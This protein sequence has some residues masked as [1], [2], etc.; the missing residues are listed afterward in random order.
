ML[1][2]AAVASANHHGHGISPASKAIAKAY[3]DHICPQCS[4]VFERKLHLKQHIQFVHE[5]QRPLP[6]PECDRAFAYNADLKVHLRSVHRKL[7]PF[8]CP[9]CPQVFTQR[10]GLNRHER[11]THNQETRFRCEPCAKNF[12]RQS[13]L[14]KHNQRFHPQPAADS[15]HP[16]LSYEVMDALL[17]LDPKPAQFFTATPEV[18]DTTLAPL[19]F[20]PADLDPE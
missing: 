1:V 16:P 17:E 15:A 20:P 2:S 13:G 19:E 6:C 3:P 4:K 5:K 14:N 10:S 12:T 9:K 8:S 7:K 11:T 18:I